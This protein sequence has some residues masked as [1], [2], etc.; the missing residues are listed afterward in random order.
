M[1]LLLGTID[2]DTIR[3]IGRWSKDEMLRCLQVTARTLMHRHA[4]TMVA[5]GDYTLVP[6]APLVSAMA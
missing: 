2:P 1:A 6:A 4:A 5:A 3:L